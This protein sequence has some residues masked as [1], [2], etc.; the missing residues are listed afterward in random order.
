MRQSFVEGADGP[1]GQLVVEEFGPEVLLRGGAEQAR[2]VA[3]F[4]CG[5]RLRVG[6]DRDAFGGH[7]VAQFREVPEPFAVDDEAVEGVAD[8]DAPRLGVADHGAAFRQI[9]VEVEVG[10]DD[11]RPGFDHGY[12]GV[13]AHEADQSRAAARDHHVD[14]TH[15]VQQRSGSLVTRGQQG[16]G[17]RVDAFAA[18]RLAEQDGDG[19]VGAAGVAAALQHAGVARLHRERENVG[20]D[21]GA[22]LADH[23]HH[24]ERYADLAEGH[25][26]G[27]G[28]FGDRFALRRGQ[29]GD[30]FHVGGD[31]G[32]AFRRQPQAVAHG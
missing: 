25:A 31:R 15:G 4:E 11:A 9:A 18:E 8:A 17:R 1:H 13:F 16:E 22:R 29:S 3:A 12:A 20:R 26:V 24:A 14:V 30:G 23:A 21:V 28:P 7:R 5:V 19:F 6:V 10:V 32:D 27:T 2:G